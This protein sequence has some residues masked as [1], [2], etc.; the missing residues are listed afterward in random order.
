MFCPVCGANNEAG[1]RFCYRCGRQ[2]TEAGEQA[3]QS[4]P[5]WRDFQQQPPVPVPLPPV[6]APPPLPD[7]PPL[8]PPPQVIIGAPPTPPRFSPA[9][10]AAGAVGAVAAVV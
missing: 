4:G 10:L 5:A 8:P 2:L 3:P 9:F 7:V 1:A 6:P